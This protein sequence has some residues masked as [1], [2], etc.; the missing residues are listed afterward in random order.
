LTH[1]YAAFH[2][3]RGDKIKGYNSARGLMVEGEDARL[4]AY[5]ALLDRKAPEIK[6]IF[7][8][9]DDY[10]AADELRYRALSLLLRP[11]NRVTTNQSSTLDRV[12]TRCK[13]ASV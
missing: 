10:R 2:V 4:S 9:T 5:I 1:P 6:S 13:A 8:M 11:K 12:T 3:R 7:L